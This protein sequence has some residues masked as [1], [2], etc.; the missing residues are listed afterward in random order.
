MRYTAFDTLVAPAR[1]SSHPLRLLAGLGL[2][3]A[4][5]FSMAFLYV[6]LAVP[7][8]GIGGTGLAPGQ[9]PAGVLVMLFQFALLIVALWAALRL[10][11]K[12]GLVSLL[13]PPARAARHFLRCAA[14]LLPLYLLVF[15]LPM[16]EDYTPQPNLDPGV[17]LRWLPLAVMAVMVQIAAEELTFRGYLQ[18]QLAARF[19]HPAVWIGLPSLLF[20]LMHYAP[21][22]AGDNTWVIVLWAALFGTA[23]ADLTARAGTLGPAIALHFLNN[24]F[25]ILITAPT[26]NMD[27]L[28]LYTVPLDLSAP[29][30]V[31]YVLPVEAGFVLCAWLAARLALRA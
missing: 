20:G 28:A 15:I 8:A 21:G 6:W 7:F 10:V 31:W 4:I 18:S 12:R 13:G 30:I 11:H 22:M 16:P 9:T 2:M 19:A 26:G 24:V 25:A 14:F 5:F 3:V 23:A 27:G 1:P 29:G 17:W